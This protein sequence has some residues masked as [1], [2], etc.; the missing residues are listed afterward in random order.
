MTDNPPDGMEQPAPIAADDTREVF[1]PEGEIGARLERLVSDLEWLGV[2]V[3]ER[4]FADDEVEQLRLEA[5]EM[6]IT[7]ALSFLVLGLDQLL[8]DDA[9]PFGATTLA[10]L[11]AVRRWTDSGAA[12]SI[13]DVAAARDFLS[14]LPTNTHD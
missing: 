1:K 13:D 2:Q 10:W 9:T 14:R 3:S 8:A 12:L 11:R 5:A 6:L 7:S 4:T